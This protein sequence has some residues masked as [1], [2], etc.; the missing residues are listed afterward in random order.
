MA[1][2]SESQ[3]AKPS[4]PLPGIGYKGRNRPSSSQIS[5]DTVWPMRSVLEA[6]RTVPV[7]AAKR[8]GSALIRMGHLRVTFA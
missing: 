4:P 5:T 7:M 3:I 8:K 2:E 6:G 1:P